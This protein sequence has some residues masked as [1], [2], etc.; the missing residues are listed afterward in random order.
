MVDYEEHANTIYR[1]YESGGLRLQDAFYQEWPS[2]AHHVNN[3][4]I[5]MKAEKSPHVIHA[6]PG[7]YI[8]HTR[9]RA[10]ETGATHYIHNDRVFLSTDRQQ[11]KLDEREVMKLLKALSSGR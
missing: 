10:L 2:L 11:K 3:L 9:D 5:E 6:E 4:Y 1:S 8:D 7:E